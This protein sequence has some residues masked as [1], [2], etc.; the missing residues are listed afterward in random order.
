MGSAEE[1]YVPRLHVARTTMAT[2]WRWFWLAV[3]F[4][5]ITPDGLAW[6]SAGTVRADRRGLA[7]RFAGPVRASA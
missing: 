1:R 6:P 7:S 5:A 3:G 2:D 4:V